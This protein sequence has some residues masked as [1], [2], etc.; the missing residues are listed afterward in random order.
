MFN[1]I[2]SFYYRKFTK[3][4]AKRGLFSVV[5]QDKGLDYK[6]K[7]ERKRGKQGYSAST[8]LN[9]HGTVTLIGI[10]QTTVGIQGRLKAPARV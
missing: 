8:P 5:V 4:I 6:D 3:G 9:P 2:E 10:Q 1:L 7:K